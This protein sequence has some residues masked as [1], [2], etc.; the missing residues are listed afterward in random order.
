MKNSLSYIKQNIHSAVKKFGQN[1]L[2]DPNIIKNIVDAQEIDKETCVIEIGPGLGALTGALLQK[3][4]KVIAY[5]IDKKLIP[6]L[7]EN[8]SEFKNFEIINQDFM[9]LDFEK[10]INELKK[11]HKKIVVISNLPYYISSQIII[12]VLEQS[13]KIKS[14]VFMMQKEFGE[15]LTAKISTK[16]YNNFTILVQYYCE[17]EKLFNVPP[18][19]FIPKPKVDSTV[20][21]FISKKEK[22]KIKNET[23]FFSF[24]KQMFAQKRKTILN[25]LS[26]YILDKDHS[27]EILHKANIEEKLR[28]ENLKI[29]EFIK[30]FQQIKK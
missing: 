3:A 20:V 2:I 10:T 16:K 25:N 12:K 14:C 5:E 19:V 7:K 4:N 27:R 18:S 24:L 26:N 9:K 13:T 1:F 29:E 15:R 23:Q 28:P 6:L 22:P 11:Q 21:K 8:F 30:I 17:I